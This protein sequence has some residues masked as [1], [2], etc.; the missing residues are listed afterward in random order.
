[1]TYTLVTATALYRGRVLARRL[2]T[3]SKGGSILPHVHKVHYP[4]LSL[5]LNAE[6]CPQPT[7]LA[8]ILAI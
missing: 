2:R 3:E 4:G 1:V 5:S 8:Y 7:G 6:P